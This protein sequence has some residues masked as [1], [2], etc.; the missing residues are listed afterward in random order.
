VTTRVDRI[1]RYTQPVGGHVS[2]SGTM[3]A[4]RNEDD[5]VF[6]SME[7]ISDNEMMPITFQRGARFRNEES[8]ISLKL[9]KRWWFHQQ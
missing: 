3:M 5:L 6:T 1:G 2:R 8:R 7:V 9:I 4:A